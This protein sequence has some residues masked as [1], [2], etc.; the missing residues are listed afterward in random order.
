MKRMLMLMVIIL[1]MGCFVSGCATL[2]WKPSEDQLIQ[3]EQNLGIA[4]FTEAGMFVVFDSLCAA[5]AIDEKSCVIGY[6]ADTEWD[7]AYLLAIN[8]IADYRAGKTDQATMQKYVTAAMTSALRIVALIKN[9]NS[10]KP[11]TLQMKVK[12]KEMAPKPVLVAP[13][14]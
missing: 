5:K 1:T 11:A 9:L 13:K 8:A 3:Y 14:K 6:A 2:G 4:N 12:G 10:S 7:G